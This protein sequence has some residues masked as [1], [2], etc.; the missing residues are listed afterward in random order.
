MKRRIAFLLA[1]LVCAGIVFQTPMTVLAEEGYTYN[2]DWFEDVQYS[3]DAYRTVGSFAAAELGLEKNFMKPEG[4]YV[5][6]NLVYSCDTGNNRIVEIQRNEDDTF[7]VSR[8]ITEFNGAEVNTFNSPTDLAISEDGEFFIADKANGRIL[9]LDKDLN[10]MMSF[11]KPTDNT[12]DQSLDFLPEKLNIDTAGR[13][14]CIAVNVNKGLIKFENDGTFSGF[15]G[16]TP[17]TYSWTD[18]IAKKFAT[19]EQRAQMEA[20]VPTEYDNLYTDE[21]G[22]IYVTTTNVDPNDVRSGSVNPVRRLN[23]IGN[24]ILIR[25]GN[26]HIIGDP[27]WEN[28]GGYTGCSLLTD[29]TALENGIYATLDKTRG[30]VFV[31]ND[32]GQLLY[33]FGSGGNADGYFRQPESLEH[34]GRDI[35]VLDSLENSITLFTPTEFGEEIYN[36]IDLFRQGRYTECGEAWQRVMN[37]NG[38]YDLAYIG[39]GRALIGEKKFEEAL[40]YFKLKFDDDNYTK[41]FKQYRKQWVE[42][43]IVLIFVVFF[44]V[45][46]LPL[47]M[48]RIKR[49]KFQID[50]SDAFKYNNYEKKEKK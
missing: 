16:A 14:Y 34:M 2:Y 32:Q 28:A 42:E 38:N 4:M 36:A 18:Y 22:F 12:F 9:K 29:V 40:P 25:N 37:M 7:T 41:A 15:V 11:T 10:Y 33:A 31:Y 8:I 39:I 1:F 21:D 17:V 23:M 47:A 45:M 26:F 5:K 50:T 27:K 49:L 46:C 24:D 13:V 43:H 6:G 30:R 20:F 19:K 35:L 3:P 44:V 48:G